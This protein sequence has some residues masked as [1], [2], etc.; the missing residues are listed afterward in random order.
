[1]PAIRLTETQKGALEKLY[2]AEERA[3]KIEHQGAAWLGER[4][5]VAG[6]T[7]LALQRKGLVL[8]QETKKPY[9][10][11]VGRIRQPGIQLVHAGKTKA[12]S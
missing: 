3:G 7:L 12:R 1:V 8:V 2:A 6:S 4:E 9:R 11:L 10:R 5:G